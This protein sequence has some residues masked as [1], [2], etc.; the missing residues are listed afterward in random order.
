M[1]CPREKKGRLDSKAPFC[2]WDLD[3]FRWDASFV[4][5]LGYCLG[6]TKD[7]NAAQKVIQG[8]NLFEPA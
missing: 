6:R 1:R 3:R 8:E 7:E 4:A 5:K 2:T